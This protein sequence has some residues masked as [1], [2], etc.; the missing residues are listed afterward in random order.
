MYQVLKSVWH[1]ATEPWLF[2]LANMRERLEMR[3]IDQ[4]VSSRAIFYQADK[5]LE[6]LKLH[7]DRV[8]KCFWL[9][10]VRWDTQ[11][12]RGREE[13]SLPWLFLFALRF[14]YVSQCLSVYVCIPCGCL[15]RSE[16]DTRFPGTRVTDALSHHVDS[17]SWTWVLWKR[18][19]CSLTIMPSLHMILP[20]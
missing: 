3:L 11:L 14:I 7:N 4:T 2:H 17:G 5:D 1:S 16:E 19:K 13:L 20:F 12:R 18:N 15:K 10:E 6:V 8:A 9:G